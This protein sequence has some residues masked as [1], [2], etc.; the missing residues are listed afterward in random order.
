MP[1]RGGSQTLFVFKD[2]YDEAKAETTGYEVTE[3]TATPNAAA[4]VASGWRDGCAAG[5]AKAT[6][7]RLNHR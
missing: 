6:V 5:W 7:P 2:I 4:R 1:H 3:A